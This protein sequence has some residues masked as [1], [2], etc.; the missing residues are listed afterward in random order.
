MKQIIHRAA[1]TVALFCIATFCTSTLLI[2]VLASHERVAALKSFIL[3]PGIPILVLAMAITGG[4]GI[5][6]AKSRKGQL[7]EAKRKRMTFIA[8]NG[9]LILIPC[10]IFLDRF[11]SAQT[12]DSAFYSF[13][14]LEIIAEF[15]ALTLMSANIRDG[16]KLSG[17]IRRKPRTTENKLEK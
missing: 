9:I 4:T 3:M 5:S 13:Q 14:T 17:R 16:F 2:E 11:A 6:L 7:V 10:A 12:F 1:A 8:A 15:I